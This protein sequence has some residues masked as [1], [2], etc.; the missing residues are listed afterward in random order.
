MIGSAS[1]EGDHIAS[2]ARLVQGLLLQ[3]GLDSP[4][5]RFSLLGR[6]V[7][8]DGSF[9]FVGHVHNIV[10]NVEFKILGGQLLIAR[11]GQKPGLY[12]IGAFRGKLLNGVG[13][14]MVIGEDQAL[15]GN[16]RARATVVKTDGG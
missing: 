14:D 9:N 3:P 15:I 13:T 1:K 5:S 7:L 10:E 12:E 4:T 16:K 8:G 11:P 6:H 2:E